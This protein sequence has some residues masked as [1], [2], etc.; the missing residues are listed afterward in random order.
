MT[1]TIASTASTAPVTTQGI[2]SGLD[3]ASIVDKL[4]SVASAPLTALQT[5]ETAY[6]TKLSAFGQVSSALSTFQSTIAPLTTPSAFQ[7]FAASIGDSTIASVAIDSANATSLSAGAHTLTVSQLADAQ[8]TASSAFTSTTSAVGTGSVTIDVGSWN[9]SYSTFT[10]NGTVGSKTITIDSTNNSLSGIRDAINAAGAGVTASIVNDGSGNRLVVTGST[11]GSAN[12]FRISTNDSD[13]NNVD[14][15]GL[16]QIAFDPTASGGTPQTQHLSNAVNANFTIDGLAISKP[17]N[18]VTDAIAG[19]KLGLTKVD[20]TGTTFSIARDTSSATTAIKNFVSAYNTIE[21]GISTLTSYDAT[22]NTAG[23]LN[24]DSTT[25]LISTRLQ[26]LIATVVPTGGSISNLNDLGITFGSDGQLKLDTTKLASALASD[27]NSVSKIFAKTGTTTDALVSYADSTSNTQSG[28]H[29]LSIS[30]IATQGSLTGSTSAGLTITAGVNDSIDVTL[31]NVTST[32]TIPPGTYSDAS[33]LATVLQSKINGTT[34]FSTVASSVNVSATNG[35][36]SIGS[37]RYGSASAV[38]IAGNGGSGLFGTTPTATT[39][40]DVAGTLDGIAFNGAGQ[41]V[42]GATGTS[43][44]GL[45]LTIT[46]GAT[47]PRG[48][49]ALT[50]GIAASVSDSLTQFLD[51]T[52]G[53]LTSATAGLNKSIT[54]IKSQEDAWTPRL[55][56][57]RAQYTAQYNAMDALVASLNSTGT[58]LTQ[59]LTAIAAQTNNSTK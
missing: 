27:P 32:I 31:D 29:A 41:T 57:I 45:K 49:V 19:L 1:T 5:Q 44:E 17:S 38:K 35:V 46:G 3:I 18:T 22:S 23:T 55:D 48:T 50:R 28:S 51:P 53:L 4:V 24:G 33:S 25:R 47:G 11:T 40:L 39:G 36:L 54:D 12:G 59:Q 34:A 58:Y 21:S 6:Q 52:S 43:A 8:R 14:A 13:G 7:S 15:S 26:S 56:A 16:S 9:S 20:T 37:N 30:Q 42:I 2:G 10:P